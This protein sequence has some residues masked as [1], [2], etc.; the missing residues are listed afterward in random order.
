MT[1]D[2][3][4]PRS[5]VCIGNLRSDENNAGFNGEFDCLDATS[6][7]STFERWQVTIGDP[8][9]TFTH[10]VHLWQQEGQVRVFNDNPLTATELEE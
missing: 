1:L 6:R 3:R 5:S 4:S 2:V 7:G 9:A 10:T 8:D